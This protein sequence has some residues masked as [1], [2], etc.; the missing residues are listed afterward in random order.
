MLIRVGSGASGIKEYLEK[1]QKKDRFFSRDE[2][3]ERVILAGN[4]EQTNAI[5]ES[6]PDDKD[7]RYFHYTLA[8]K[9]HYIEPEILEEISLEFEQ[10]I[11]TAYGDDELNF[12]AEAHL[13]KI[14]SYEDVDGNKVERMPHIHVVIPKVNLADGKTYDPLVRSQIKYLDA[15]QECV[16]AKY[17]LASPKDNLRV[18]FNSSS[19]IISRYKGDI[20]NGHNKEDKTKI[21]NFILANKSNSQTDLFMQLESAG[22]VVKMRNGAKPEQSYINI[23]LPGANKGVNLKDSVFRNEFLKLNETDKLAFLKIDKSTSYEVANVPT[24]ASNKAQHNL[25]EWK[26][27]KALEARYLPDSNVKERQEYKQFTYENKVI[28]LQEKHQQTITKL[29]LL[30]AEE[31]GS[32]TINQ[33]EYDN[34]IRK[35]GRDADN[36][37]SNL[38][39]VAITNPERARTKLREL[40]AG[41]NTGEYRANI[42]LGN[43]D[44]TTPKQSRTEQVKEET[45]REIAATKHEYSIKELNKLIKADALLEL[46]EKTHG[47]NR[48]LYF[49]SVDT[50]GGERI[51][52]GNRNLNMVDF[53]TKELNLSFKEALP[54][55]SNV[56]NMQ[57]TLEREK[58]LLRNKKYLHD[59]YK[60]WFINYKSERTNAMKETQH[61]YSTSRHNITHKSNEKIKQ[62]KA[63]KS[64]SKTRKSFEINLAKSQK[65]ID[66]DALQKS[67]TAQT[68]EIKAKFNTDMQSAYRTFL[69]EKATKG[70]DEALEELRRLRIKFDAGTKNI[71]SCVERYQEFRLNISHEI[72]RNGII[73]YKLDDKVIFRDEGKRLD[74][75]NSQPD[76]LKLSLEL[77]MAKFGNQLTLD[78]DENFRKKVVETALKNNFNIEFVDDFSK[79]YHQQ[80]KHGLQN[81]T[82][83][84]QQLNDKFIANSPSRCQY[85]ST[86]KV[87]IMNDDGKTKS[88]NLHTVRNLKTNETTEITNN[89]LDYLASNKTLSAGQILD[90]KLA[91][92]NMK[93]SQT[94]EHKLRNEIKQEILS[95]RLSEFNTEI[96]IKHNLD[97]PLTTRG[98]FI[99]LDKTKFGKEFALIK[100]DTGFI[101]LDKPEMLNEIKQQNLQ[102][103]SLVVLSVVREQSVEKTRDLSKLKLIKADNFVNFNDLQ[104]IADLQVPAAK[105]RKL[106][107]ECMGEISDIR[108][109]KTPDKETLYRTTVKTY[110]GDLKV[111]YLKDKQNI[112]IGK[113]CYIR[114][115]SNNQIDIVDLTDSKKQQLD[116]AKQKLEYD[117]VDSVEFAKLNKIGLRNLRGNDVFFAEYQTVENNKPQI[118]TKYGDSIKEQIYHSELKTG[119]VIALVK[120]T[121][122]EMY[123]EQKQVIELSQLDLN[124][125]AEIDTKL[126]KLHNLES[127]YKIE[128]NNANL[129]NNHESN[130]LDTERKDLESDKQD[131]SNEIELD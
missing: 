11:K 54:Y 15:F 7:S 39:R 88:V 95:Q 40:S 114:Q 91:D 55:L 125:D 109:F 65:V 71:L 105:N 79:N 38:S 60:E 129:E 17:G 46:A 100:T 42:E 92:G 108:T 30:G 20:F 34:V 124:I 85:Q 56:Y 3:D 28:F 99:K 21:L 76:N 64:L 84:I 45:N 51:K 90:T 104:L 2:L 98:V 8:F 107:K 101:R 24:L 1:G 119:D 80:L 123:Y 93:F 37:E 89:S 36:L 26:D 127:E 50:A 97:Q 25:K 70:D 120:L 96:K 32:G 44:S 6:I 116:Y 77:A 47:I 103:R 118:I 117:N 35:I 43:A 111:F 83:Q 33:R 128:N 87:E 29:N 86:R 53:V 115:L 72:D 18:E 131:N 9:E 112:E 23:T 62:I 22:Y 57:N 16:N 68:K 106:V 67:R 81:G 58:P 5:I 52:C 66:L 130:S 19:E 69:V 12:Y 73:N 122:K 113:F 48:E 121:E 13:P 102:P 41:S 74:V 59:E 49:I 75:V 31:N 14:R 110:D 78:G 126:A 63:D 94:K 82:M 10:F 4:L 61:L 27:Y